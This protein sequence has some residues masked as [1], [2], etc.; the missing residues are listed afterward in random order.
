M[1][2][3]QYVKTENNGVSAARNLGI[4]KANG[5]WIAFC[6]ADDI[7]FS[8]KLKTQF[9]SLAGDLWSYTDSFYMGSLYKEGTKRSHLSKL[10]NGNVFNALILENVVTTSSVLI[11]KQVVQKCNGFDETLPALEDW[12]LWLSIAKEH[13]ISLV[14]EPMLNYRVYSGSTSRNARAMLPLHIKV[15]N[16]VIMGN[17]FNKLK[18]LALSKAYSICS[19]IAEQGKDYSFALYCAYKAFLYSPLSTTIIKRLVVCCVKLFIK[20]RLKTIISIVLK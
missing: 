20:D 14:K 5:D 7:W 18:N 4:K 12:Q 11:K 19:H 15:I 9:D 1:D 6:D 2:Y 10:C 13:P 17:S 16:S 8:E 3:I